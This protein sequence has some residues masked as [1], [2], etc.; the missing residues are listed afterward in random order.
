MPRPLRSHI[1]VLH[2]GRILEEGTHRDLIA[3]NGH[4]A[5]LFRIQAR[6]YLDAR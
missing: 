5:T 4:Y 6:A 1:V 2:H 3:A